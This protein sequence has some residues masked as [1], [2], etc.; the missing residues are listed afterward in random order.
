MATHFILGEEDRQIRIEQILSASTAM[1]RLLNTIVTAPDPYLSR[2][3]DRWAKT[4]RVAWD[5]VSIESTQGV[6]GQSLAKVK[7]WLHRLRELK[8]DEVRNQLVHLDLSGNVPDF[9]SNLE[10]A[11]APAIIDFTGYWRPFEYTE[12]IMV[13]DGITWKGNGLDLAKKVGLI[14][15]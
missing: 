11:L 15:F 4:D 1:H 14:D 2:R 7:P 3:N 6:N 8:H 9:P 10:P 12:A 5:G 13:A